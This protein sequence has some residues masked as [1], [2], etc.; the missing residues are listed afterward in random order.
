MPHVHVNQMIS[1]TLVERSEPTRSSRFRR[2]EKCV[3]YKVN[4]DFDSENIVSASQRIDNFFEEI[5]DVEL[6][7][8]HEDDFYSCYVVTP[9]MSQDQRIYVPPH[10]VGNR[11]PKDLFDALY[12]VSQSNQEFL[13]EGE[14]T[15]RVCIVTMPMAG[16]NKAPTT[17]LKQSSMKKSVISISNNNSSCAFL[18]I[19]LGMMLNSLP[20]DSP[21]FKRL[22]SNKE[23]KRHVRAAKEL[24]N[25]C[26]MDYNHHVS[27][28]QLEALQAVVNSEVKIVVIDS[29]DTINKIF[30]GRSKSKNIVFL[31]YVNP[32]DGNVGH[33][34]LIPDIDRYIP[35]RIKMCLSCL[36]SY[37]QR[38]QHRCSESCR[39]CLSIPPCTPDIYV[40]CQTCNR[41]FVSEMC[42]GLHMMNNR[43]IT[44]S[45]C[46]RCRRTEKSNHNCEEYHCRS[47]SESYTIQP[48]FCYMKPLSLDKLQEED[49]VRKFV[50]CYDIEATQVGMGTDKLLHKANLLI[51]R[52]E[53]DDCQSDPSSCNICKHE[54]IFEGLNCVN[55]FGDYI[56]DYL[57]QEAGRIGSR[58][59]VFAHNARGYDS[60]F[61]LRDIIERQLLDVEVI[62]SGLKLLRV[63][64]A[65]V[66]FVD[67]LSFFH[68][69]LAALPKAFGL[70]NIVKGTFPHLFNKSENWN[71]KG[72][73]PPLEYY[74]IEWMKPEAAKEVQE[75]HANQTK[76]WAFRDE[77]IKY[78]RQDVV[79]LSDAIRKFRKTFMEI[80]SLDPIT[81]SFTLASVALEVFRSRFLVNIKFATTPLTYIKNINQS[82]EGKVFLDLVQKIHNIKL[83]KEYRIGP[84][85]VDGADVQNRTVYEY[86]GCWYHGCPC[87]SADHHKYASTLNRFDH[88]KSLGWKVHYTF[89]CDF[90]TTCKKYFRYCQQRRKHHRLLK[91]HGNINLR[92]AFRGG[93][94][95]N[96]KFYE[97]APEG[98]E[99]KYVDVISEYPAVMKQCRYPVGHPELIEEDFDE[100]LESY[101]GF[102]KLIILPPQNLYL[103]VLPVQVNGKMIF[104]LCLTCAKNEQQEDCSHGENERH[105]VGT[106]TTS[107]LSVALA[108]GYTIVTILQVLHYNETSDQLFAKNVNLWL[109]EK[110]EASGYPAW[111]RYADDKEKYIQEYFGAEGIILDRDKISVNPARRQIA[112]LLLNS[113][114]GKMG[115]K[116]NQPKTTIARHSHE[117]FDII[118]DPKKVV[119]SELMMQ[120]SAIKLTWETAEDKDVISR[121]K[122]VAVAAFVT[123]HA[124]L[125]LFKYML[126]IEKTRPFSLLYFDTDSCIF[127]R[128]LTDPEIELGSSLGCLTDEFP[129]CRITVFCAV[130]PKC[131]GITYIDEYGKEQSI[132]K[133][134]GLCLHV[135]ALDVINFTKLYEMAVA[136]VDGTKTLLEVPQFQIRSSKYHELLTSYML[137]RFQPT[138]TKRIFAGNFTLPFGFI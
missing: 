11:S 20:K 17:A 16:K 105:L 21:L 108:H 134:K 71:Y 94:V 23:K 96:L 3:T 2:E 95:N 45:V 9:N 61:I 8:T 22:R 82:I 25:K 39:A 44:A 111:V 109:K 74:G 106:W 130:G 46:Q 7:G 77:I 4:H 125:H 103:P 128:K 121:N 1:Y 99:I 98:Y 68:A 60:Q 50:V 51:C 104:P 5:L 26:G 28:P 27:I 36:Q 6:Q 70:R 65:N 37:D 33:F 138:S 15:L 114:F 79:I 123:S 119:K 31:E 24:A 12:N 122:N 83:A 64:V 90:R 84:Y 13:L 78:C 110:Q 117:Y 43:C 91:L 115:Q 52:T 62:S 18:A 92:D 42:F 126:W 129:N 112:K 54:L 113:F 57:A 66:S 55:N 132:I 133:L 100:T 101:F 85:F 59:Y 34:N 97:V 135:K 116:D 73:V 80:T 35:K 89:G 131:Y 40:E 72:A 49:A 137:K 107:E 19:A 93:R 47:C 32:I 56:Y 14:F 10:R 63:R 29:L 58:V 118:T 88:I 76:L 69:P 48:H 53:C 127:L 67:S 41:L 102:V 75:W 86:A 38:Y 124:R 87:T 30:V 136:Y 120:D 81:R